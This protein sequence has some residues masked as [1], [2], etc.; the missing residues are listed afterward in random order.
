MEGQHDI[1]PYSIM[2]QPLGRR[3]PSSAT[4]DAQQQPTQPRLVHGAQHQQA[5]AQVPAGH[6]QSS[7]SNFTSPDAAQRPQQPHL[8]TPLQQHPMQ[9]PHMQV[10]P[11]VQQ[12]DLDAFTPP[13]HLTMMRPFR[14]QLP[15]HM[16][17]QRLAGPRQY[18]RRPMDPAAMPPVLPPPVTALAPLPGHGSSHDDFYM[19]MYLTAHQYLATRGLL[20]LVSQFSCKAGKMNVL[21]ACRL[22]D[23]YHHI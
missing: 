17:D 6:L 20:S 16:L 15:E 19:T 10:G 1:D 18:I 14:S 22:S 7:L 2:Q 13:D 9:Q 3:T 23:A 8:H 21:P 4:D 11:S 5:H 12:S